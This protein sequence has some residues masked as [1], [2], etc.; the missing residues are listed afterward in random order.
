MKVLQKALL[1][2]LALALSIA[3]S[4]ED[5]PSRPIKIVSTAAPGGAFDVAGRIV[6]ERMSKA[7]GTSIA[8]E[9][10]QG[11]VGVIAGS[12]VAQASPDGYTWLFSDQSLFTVAN[13]PSE[14][15]RTQAVRALVP[16]S[17]F[18]TV[19]LA[20][21]VHPSL[22]VR[23]VAELINHARQNP[24]TVKYGSV[25]IGSVFKTGMEM[26]SQPTALPLFE[27]PYKSTPQALNAIVAGEIDAMLVDPSAARQWSESGKLRILAVT[28][29]NALSMLPGVP[30]VS[31]TVPGY[32]VEVWSGMFA[33][34]GGTA[35]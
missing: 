13:H 35:G 24:G 25:G 18:A 23:T 26:L 6:T 7:L 21:A 11:G 28:S 8:F 17:L 2:G 34:R 33:P 31:A 15:Q 22:T 12:A 30:P 3:A 16:V 19:P 4:A 1:A 20:L 10:R 9:N 29:Q 32:R 14:T 5:F 27:V